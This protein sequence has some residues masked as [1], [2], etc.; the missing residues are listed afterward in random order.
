MTRKQGEPQ[1]YVILDSLNRGWLYTHIPGDNF[2]RVM[3]LNGL[4]SA[5]AGLSA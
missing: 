4:N 3:Q 1:Y 2:A 5:A